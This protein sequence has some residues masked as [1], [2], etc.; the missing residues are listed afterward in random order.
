MA[1][2]IKWVGWNPKRWNFGRI[3]FL[4]FDEE[5]FGRKVTGGTMWFGLGPVW[6]R[7]DGK[8]EILGC[9]F[10]W[11]GLNSREWTFGRKITK[12]TQVLQ[13]S[14]DSRLG[15]RTETYF[16]GEE[17]GPWTCLGP[18]EILHTKPSAKQ[19]L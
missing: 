5:G 9:E 15:I 14:R 19:R 1:I 2:K 7:R 18:I 3:L 8:L 13:R 4:E 16:T 10:H 11:V 17:S 6:F 12:R